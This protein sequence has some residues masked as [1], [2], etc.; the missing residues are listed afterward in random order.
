M[1]SVSDFMIKQ[2]RSMGWF[3]VANLY[4][5]NGLAVSPFTVSGR[6]CL[7]PS[8]EMLFTTGKL[9]TANSEVMEGKYI[10][11]APGFVGFQQTIPCIGLG[12]LQ[13]FDAL[14]FS[15]ERFYADGEE[16]YTPTIPKPDQFDGMVAD[17]KTKLYPGLDET[18]LHGGNV[19]STVNMYPGHKNVEYSGVR[20][21]QFKIFQDNQ[22]KFVEAC[23]KFFGLGDCM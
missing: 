18:H 14:L 6:V 8:A 1:A 15:H 19:I 9:D 5:D 23:N 21:D 12:H 3:S 10:T 22:K 13:H 11:M 17:A 2:I 4:F 16:F 7:S 20:V